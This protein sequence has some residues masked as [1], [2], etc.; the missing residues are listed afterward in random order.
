MLMKLNAKTVGLLLLIGVA[1]LLAGLFVGAFNNLMP[2]EASAEAKSVDALFNLMMVIATIVFLI[3]EGVLLYSILKFRK[4]KGDETDAAY[5][6][7]NMALEIT[8]TAIPAVIVVV[9]SLYSYQV[10]AN[11]QTP[12]DN[13]ITIQVKGQ[14]FV[15]SFT[16]PHDSTVN[17]LSSGE[18]HLP[19]NQPIRM[20]ITA[21][22]VMHG[23][24]IPEFRIKQDAIPGRTTEARFTP[25]LA[26]VYEV[27]CYELC[28]SGHGL[29][30][31][32]V[33]VQSQEDYDK[34]V[35]SLI[36][37]PP[38]KPNSGSSPEWGKYLVISN[39]YGCGGCHY[40]ADAGIN[41]Q[42]GPAWTNIAD[43][44]GKQVPGQDART[45]L[46]HAILYPNEYVVPG[47]PANVMPQNFGT[48]M[49]DVDLN[50]IVDYLLKQTANPANT[51]TGQPAAQVTTP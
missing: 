23:F 29:M 2:A 51:G 45:R 39:K 16:Y 17:M 44:A 6:H 26:G 30:Q 36:V 37:H 38:T 15:W 10:F 50:S 35:Q 33:I 48:L 27:V 9:L 46:T 32:E 14:Q 21:A 41:G 49:D 34:Y 13:E 25:T 11:Q 7:G 20:E 22:D 12:N 42:V 3:V 40:L 4:P 31:N 5:N 24:W 28:G 1:L 18:L 43:I 19:I 8:W 47:Y